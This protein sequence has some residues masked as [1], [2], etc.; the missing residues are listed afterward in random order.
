[1]P[2]DRNDDNYE[3]GFGKP[4]RQT[5]FKKGQSGNRNG[6][7]RGSKNLNTLL[8]QELK[9]RLVV[10]ENGQRKQVTKMQAAIK[11]LVNKGLTDRRFMQ[12]LLDAI[13][14]MEVRNETSTASHAPLEGVD[15]QIIENFLKRLREGEP[16]DPET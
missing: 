6:R 5:Q 12:L 9:E 10:T 1:M 2:D 13:R 16:Y 7:P 14:Q 8:S 11:N 3:V 15:Q 4:P